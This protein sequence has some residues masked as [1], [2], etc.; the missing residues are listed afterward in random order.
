MADVW[1]QW[2]DFILNISF[3]F[4]VDLTI[5]EPLFHDFMVRDFKCDISF[6]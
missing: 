4:I 2:N 3:F 6:R 5:L 1:I